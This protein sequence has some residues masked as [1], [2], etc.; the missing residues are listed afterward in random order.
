MTMNRP[1]LL[2]VLLGS[3]LPRQALAQPVVQGRTVVGAGIGYSCIDKTLVGDS[4][5][6]ADYYIRVARRLARWLSVGG[7]LDTFALNDEDPLPSDVGLDSRGFFVQ[8]RMPRVF[9][10][11]LVV[12]FAQ[13][14]L[15][16]GLFVRGGFGLGTHAAATY[17]PGY[18]TPTPSF[19]EA[20]KVFQDPS[21]A[22][23]VAIGYERRIAKYVGLSIETLSAWEKTSNPRQI[24]GVRF[25]TNF[26]F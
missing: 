4:F 2:L 6:D 24:L 14:H 8:H 22:I 21:T 10:T 11:R 26:Q 18:N 9:R 15:P 25:G 23:S 1:L 12:G 3:V 5:C 16:L 7:E 13:V 20:E 17:G 19:T